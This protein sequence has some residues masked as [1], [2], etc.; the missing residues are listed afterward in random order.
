MF[1]ACIWLLWKLLEILGDS[2]PIESSGFEVDIILCGTILHSTINS[3]RTPHIKL[4]I[5]NISPEHQAEFLPTHHILHLAGAHLEG[6]K[7]M[8]AS[9]M[10]QLSA[11][12]VRQREYQDGA[13]N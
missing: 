13:L 12:R 2:K 6:S 1:G 7:S 5:Q 8:A 11:P 10:I 4:G 9:A 3:C